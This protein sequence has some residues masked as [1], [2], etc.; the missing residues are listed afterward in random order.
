[1][2]NRKIAAKAL[3]KFDSS[4]PQDVMNLD[5]SV[6]RGDAK[7]AAAA[8]HK[9][10]GASAT[11]SA[12]GLRKDRRRVGKTRQGGRAF[13]GGRCARSLASRGGSIQELCLDRP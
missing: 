4:V 6:R 3:S 7:A 13:P 9:I 10:K 12:E 5:Q 8:A 11:I 1:M 2:G